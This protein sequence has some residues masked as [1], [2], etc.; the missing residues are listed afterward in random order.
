[1][2]DQKSFC[3]LPWVSLQIEADGSVLPC[4]RAPAKGVLGSVRRESAKEIWNAPA[5]RKIRRDMLAGRVPEGCAECHRR[6]SWGEKS[7][8]LESNERFRALLPIVERTRANGALPSDGP[9]CLGLRFSN[10]CNFRCRSCGSRNSSSLALEESR[11]SGKPAGKAVSR[12]FQ[13]SRDAGKWV[14]PL[15]ESLHYVYFAGGEPLLDDD[16]YVFLESLLAAGR[17]DVFLVYSTNFS[18]LSHGRWDVAKLWSRFDTVRI[19]A[20]FDGVGE[21]A[22]IL[23]KGTRWAEIERNFLRLRET[24]PNVGFGIFPTVSAMNAFHLPKALSRWIELGMIREPG[25]L[26]VNALTGPSHLC[27][28]VFNERERKSLAECYRKYL[29]NGLPRVSRALRAHVA[30]ELDKVLATFREPFDPAQRK[31]FKRATFTLDRIRNERLISRFPE[32]F[33]ALYGEA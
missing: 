29:E 6:E 12:A 11:T 10:L 30:G 17:K 25:D 16:H 1:M 32:L 8:R 21:Q 31:L 27:F 20:S 23:R 2:S 15:L 7:L 13:S 14:S 24:A 18:T 9:V 28:R 26:L 33:D 19:W 3:I 5:I 22:E 4:C